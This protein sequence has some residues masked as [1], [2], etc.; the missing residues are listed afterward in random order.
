MKIKKILLSLNLF[1]LPILFLSSCDTETVKQ[2]KFVD[3]AGQEKVVEAKKTEDADEVADILEAFMLN[4]SA[5]INLNNLAYSVN[6]N[7]YTVFKDP[8]TNKTTKSN[9]RLS[10]VVAYSFENYDSYTEQ[11]VY[12][13][14][15]ISGSM[16]ISDRNMGFSANVELFMDNYLNYIHVNQLSVPYQLFGP[17]APQIKTIINKSVINKYL[18][19]SLNDIINYA[20]TYSEVDNYAPG[21][22]NYTNYLQDPKEVIENYN[23]ILFSLFD[24]DDYDFSGSV[25]NLDLK[26]KSVGSNTLTFSF[27]DES[28]IATF[29]L[30]NKLLLNLKMN[31]SSQSENEETSM[32]LNI[33]FLPTYKAKRISEDD[34]ASATNLYDIIPQELIDSINEDYE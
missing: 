5:P 12:S 32:A 2:I 34:K 16:P 10:S 6:F 28:V 26:V 1:A 24:L 20:S 7:Y 15:K 11:Y 30:R 13:L 4:E 14:M 22:E 17:I 25:E 29:D 3:S 33:S 8:D 19:T 27:N 18:Y 21:I 23:S 31:R 9:M